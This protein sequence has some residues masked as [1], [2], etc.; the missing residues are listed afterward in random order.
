MDEFPIYKTFVS[1][2]DHH[3]LFKNKLLVKEWANTYPFLFDEKDL[4]TALNQAERGYHFFEWLAAI[5]LYH[6]EGLYSLV[7]KYQ[8]KK[9]ERKKDILSELTTNDVIEYMRSHPEHGKTQCPDL[10][11][12]KPDSSDW[13]FLEVKSSSDKLSENQ[14]EFFKALAEKSGKS[15]ELIEFKNR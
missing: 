5:L 14:M 8:F 6:T 3:D 15:V 11:V 4:S 10:L 1:H 9:H 12:Y 7:E 13:F 2:P